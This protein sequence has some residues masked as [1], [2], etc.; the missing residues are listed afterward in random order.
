MNCVSNFQ[1][2]WVW[3]AF[4]ARRVVN[5]ASPAGV[6][7]IRESLTDCTLRQ[8]VRSRRADTYKT[9]H[10]TRSVSQRTYILYLAVLTRKHLII[11]NA[12]QMRFTQSALPTTWRVHGSRE[13]AR[14]LI[15]SN[16][17]E[18]NRHT[19]KRQMARGK[20][21]EIVMSLAKGWGHCH[22]I[23]QTILFTFICRASSVKGL[24]LVIYTCSPLTLLTCHTQFVPVTCH[25]LRKRFI[26]M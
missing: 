3:E 26:H 16:N 8:F 20:N 2:I 1:H 13:R 12:H 24:S 5:V 15:H 18:Q 23:G 9:A 17:T 19:N 21:K 11:D 7:I 14:N 6:I 22:V 10:I 25:P 4:V